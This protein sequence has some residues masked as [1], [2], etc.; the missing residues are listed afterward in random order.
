M[1]AQPASLIIVSRH[2]TA[3][4]KVALAGVVQMDY[5]NFEVI[6]VTDPA[7]AGAVRGLGLPVKLT[8]YDQPNISAARN[9]GLQLAAA[10]VV[11][12]MDDDAVPEPSWLSRL[13]APFTNPQVTAAAGYVLGR[14]GLAWQWRAMWVDSDG[15]DHPFDAGHQTSLHRGTPQR[16][17]KTQGTNCAFRRDAVLALGGFDEAYT[18]YLDETDL[19]LRLAAQGGVTAVVPGAVVHHG[20]AQSSM[21][22]QNRVPTDLTQI[23]HSLAYFITK[24]G[25]NP[26][27]LQKHVAHQRA[28]LIRLVLRGAMGPFTARRL[29]AGLQQGIALSKEPANHAPLMP[30]Q[31]PFLP[32]PNTGPR[33]G[34][35]LIG[36]SADRHLLEQ[37]AQAARA[38]GHIV[39]L[40]LLSRGIRPHTHR[41]TENGWWEQSGGRFGRAFRNGQRFV[42]CNAQ[43]RRQIEARRLRELRPINSIHDDEK[44]LNNP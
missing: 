14:S 29:M 33:P 44:K 11:A 7:S 21:R 9:I 25:R 22:T 35:L 16:T 38:N 19:N 18:F 27:A 26:A 39:T 37:Q 34:C 12:F 30:G 13:T 6:V 10:P 3:A 42:W 4:L 31:T 36:R 24:H 1:T 23:G 15:F 40:I 43:E 17:I 28:R 5:P 8:E 32:M 41:F 20:F 2:R